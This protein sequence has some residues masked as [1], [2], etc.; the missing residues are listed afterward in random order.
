MRKS[1]KQAEIKMRPNGQINLGTSKII[2][3]RIF[4]YNSHYVL[5]RSKE[6]S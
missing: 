2:R 4:R 3:A 5:S 1:R 6:N